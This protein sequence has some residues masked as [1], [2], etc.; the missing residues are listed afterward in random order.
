MQLRQPRLPPLWYGGA[1][2]ENKDAPPLDERNASTTHTACMT[3]CMARRLI[4]AELRDRAA[5]AGAEA[6][7]KRLPGKGRQIAELACRALSLKEKVE[8][9]YEP[10]FYNPQ[11]CAKECL[12]R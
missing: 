7:T 3:R 6:A 4:L 5:E 2:P 8:L 11:Q 10:L 12:G 1:L 9:V